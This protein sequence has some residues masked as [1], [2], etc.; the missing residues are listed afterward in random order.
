MLLRNA[1]YVAARADELG[2]KPLARRLRSEPVVLFRDGSGKTAALADRCCHRAAPLHLGRVVESGIRCG[3]HGLVFDGAGRC[4]TIPGQELVPQGA[5][6]RS[7]PTVEKDQLVWLWMG[8]PMLADPAKI[9]SPPTP[10]E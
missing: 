9:A 6:V 8:D 10:T 1:W 7:Y 5:Q 3:Y 2:D 4:V